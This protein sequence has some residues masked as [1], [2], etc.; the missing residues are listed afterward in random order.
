MTSL[1][2]SLGTLL[3]VAM[4]LVGLVTILRRRRARRRGLTTETEADRDRQ[5]ATAETERRMAA[6]LASRD[7]RG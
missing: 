3:P 2:N 7:M 4:T 5:A 1:G 6:Y